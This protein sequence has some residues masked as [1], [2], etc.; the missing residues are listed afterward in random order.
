VKM[1]SLFRRCNHDW[2]I[3]RFLNLRLRHGHSDY[4]AIDRICV[5]CLKKDNQQVMGHIN[6]EKAEKIFKGEKKC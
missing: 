2:E 3:T 4:T 1:F 6:L 5:K